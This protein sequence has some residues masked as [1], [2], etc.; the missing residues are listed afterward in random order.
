M[1]VD[2]KKVKKRIVSSMAQF[3]FVYVSFK[4]KDLKKNARVSSDRQH[5]EAPDRVLQFPDR[6]WI[7]LHVR[8]PA[9]V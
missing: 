7:V 1:A 5:R 6:V 2:F 8:Q 9:D 4:K 3:F